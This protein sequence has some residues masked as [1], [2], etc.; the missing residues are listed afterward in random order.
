MCMRLMFV[1]QKNRPRTAQD[2]RKGK[3][4][5]T[6]QF[7]TEFGF[8]GAQFGNWVAQG[9]NAKERQG[10]LNAAYDALMDLSDILH[11]NP[12]AISLDGSLGI[13]FGARGSGWASAH[14]EPDQVVI[15]L[16]KT[17]G[18]GSLAHEWLHALDNYF[19]KQRGGEQ[20]IGSG[21]G[22]QSPTVRATISPISLSR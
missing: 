9:K 2:W 5:T 21:L 17:R 13:S 20:K 3:D 14:Y 10:M 19:A 6:E 12:K 18:A 15:N 8:R 11:I 1:I 7:G 16:T 4:V 22:A